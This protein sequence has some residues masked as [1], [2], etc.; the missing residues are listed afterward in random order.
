MEQIDEA[1]EI[2]EDSIGKKENLRELMRIRLRLDTRACDTLSALLV[3]NLMFEKEGI[4]N[5]MAQCEIEIIDCIKK[6]LAP[7]R[8]LDEDTDR[9]VREWTSDFYKQIEQAKSGDL[10]KEF[11]EMQ[12][13]TKMTSIMTE[14]QKEQLKDLGVDMDEVDRIFSPKIREELE[15]DEY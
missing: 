8:G 13:L 4:A 5:G 3:T 2:L 1:I 9:S 15:E 14:E 6:I 7:Y 11:D 10:K 12:L